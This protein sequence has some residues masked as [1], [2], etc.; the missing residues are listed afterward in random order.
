ML[1]ALLIEPVHYEFQPP[2]SSTTIELDTSGLQC[3]LPL[4]KAKQAL[5]AM[6]SGE[7]VQVISTDKGSWRDF[8]VFCEQSGHLLLDSREEAGLYRYLLQKK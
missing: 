5:N 1:G 3:P 2:M 4:L 6:N 8:R 7:C